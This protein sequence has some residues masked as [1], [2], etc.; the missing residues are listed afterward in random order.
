MRERARTASS[1]TCGVRSLKVTNRISLPS[2]TP[3]LFFPDGMAS[4]LEKVLQRLEPLFS[5]RKQ[6]SAKQVEPRSNCSFTKRIYISTPSLNGIPLPLQLGDVEDAVLPRWDSLRLPNLRLV[7][8][9]HEHHRRA[10]RF[11]ERSSH[12]LRQRVHHR[13]QANKRRLH[14]GKVGPRRRNSSREL[15][16][17]GSSTQRPCTFRSGAKLLRSRRHISST[18]SRCLCLVRAADE[19]IRARVPLRTPFE[20]LLRKSRSRVTLLRR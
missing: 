4:Q 12:L 3:I 8:R 17:R 15:D 9:P 1:T 7:A 2:E 6:E 16:E 10:N 13:I 19:S 18:P 5:R 11:R 14:E 20:V